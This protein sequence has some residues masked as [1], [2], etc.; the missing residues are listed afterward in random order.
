MEIWQ[1]I[2]II[3]YTIISALLFVKSLHECY[4]RKKAYA[5]FYPLVVIGGF[6]WG[7]GVVFGSFWTVISLFCFILKDWI[8]FLFIFSLFWLVRSIG[9]AIF[10]LNQQFM[11]MK[12]YKPED[13]PLFFLFHDESVYFV[14]QIIFQCLTV[15]SLIASIFAGRLWILGLG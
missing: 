3:S 15:V 9:E 6:V 8:L 7:D 11:P 2:L 10:W 1:N 4:F 13:F 14:N 5:N 12:R